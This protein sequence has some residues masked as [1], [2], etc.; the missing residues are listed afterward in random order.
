MEIAAESM[1]FERA[2]HI[3]DHASVLQENQR[4]LSFGRITQLQRRLIDIR[5]AGLVEHR[6]DAGM[7]ILQ[8]GTG[9]ALEGDHSIHVE[10][11]VA[12]EIIAQVRVLHGPDAHI[13]TDLRDRFIIETMSRRR[14]VLG[15]GLDFT[16][17]PFDGF[18]QK[19]SQSQVGPA[20]CLEWL[21]VR[22]HDGTEWNMHE[23]D[24]VTVRC[25]SPPRLPGRVEDVTEVVAL[26]GID[27]V[28]ASTGSGFLGSVSQG[29]QIAGGV[30]I[31]TIS[32]S[33]QQRSLA[34]VEV[35]DQCP[36]IRSTELVRLE[37]LD[38]RVK[39]VLVEGFAAVVV[40]SHADIQ[41]IQGLVDGPHGDIDELV[42]VA[43]EF[44]VALLERDQRLG[45][46]LALFIGTGLLCFQFGD[47]MWSALSG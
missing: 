20:S 9:I 41:E 26:P 25:S 34:I 21:L 43:D 15:T 2:G 1:W 27:D 28:D 17:A 40:G 13:T 12:D 8:V 7:G 31:A 32:F 39:G 24:I 30:E 23:F 22:S 44:L 38:H 14:R 11:I 35:D 46:G 10:D 37:V 5:F 33:D 47:S 16:R 29:G 36:V 4:E 19:R 3:L 42:P 18:G 6:A 45:R